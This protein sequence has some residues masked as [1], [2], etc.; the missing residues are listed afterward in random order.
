VSTSRYTLP[1]LFPLCTVDL[2]I[3][4]LTV[5]FHVAPARWRRHLGRSRPIQPP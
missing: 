4:A 5:H 1:L 2:T 3:S